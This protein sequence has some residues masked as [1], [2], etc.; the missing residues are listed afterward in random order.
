V[1]TVRSVS[2]FRSFPQ[3]AA[4]AFEGTL[5]VPHTDGGRAWYE[6]FEADM[7]PIAP[8]PGESRRTRSLGAS[9]DAAAAALDA[10]VARGGWRHEQLH[11][12]GFSDGGTVRAL[13]CEGGA[14]LCQRMFLLA[15]EGGRRARAHVRRRG[16]SLPCRRGGAHRGRH[17]AKLTRAVVAATLLRPTLLNG[18]RHFH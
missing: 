6:A 14:A 2:D 13:A 7:T 8:A 9:V 1:A 10:L 16:G 11:L 18:G 12:F 5:E 4:L 17:T 15:G 3:T